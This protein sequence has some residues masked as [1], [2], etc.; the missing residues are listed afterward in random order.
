MLV[1]PKPTL[2]PDQIHELP[3]GC[4]EVLHHIGA[5]R[6]AE[7]LEFARQH[8]P[9]GMTGCKSDSYEMDMAEAWR[10]AAEVYEALGSTEAYAEAAPAIFP[11]TP[12][13]AEHCKKLL[14]KPHVQKD[15]DLVPIALGMVP[16]AHLISPQQRI[17]LQ[18]LPMPAP[19]TDLRHL[20]VIPDR[21]LADVCLPLEAPPHNIEVLQEDE[22]GV[23]FIADNHD[24]RFLR[25]T[26]ARGADAMGSAGRG[27][28]QH[29][30]SL[31]VG[32]SSNVLNVIRFQNRLILNNGY[33]RAYSLMRLG[34]TH[35]PAIVQVCRH[36]E[37][38]SLV[39]S[40]E[41]SENAAIYIE[42]DR[43]PLL[44]DFSDRRL[45]ISFTV[46]NSRK[47]V[48]IRYQVETGYLRC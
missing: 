6:L 27:H 32:F 37:D 1:P 10:D 47:Y 19:P 7:F 20:P 39:G 35:V 43:P 30:L 31:P 11:L 3:S 26:L 41:V 23:T 24:I 46:V 36:W 25:A 17:N 33:H 12:E 4:A 14:T 9:T 15:F 16:L 45:T 13:I 40:S 42:R 38:V 29:V 2:V 18:S 44:R 21:T 5:S 22:H 48:R 34:V 28:V 8:T